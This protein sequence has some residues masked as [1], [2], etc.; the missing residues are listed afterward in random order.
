MKWEYV[1]IEELAE[2]KSGLVSR[3]RHFL[4]RFTK[5][6]LMENPWETEDKTSYYR[7][8]EILRSK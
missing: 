1:N 7:I 6:F 5:A 8:K 4:N 3:E 2:L